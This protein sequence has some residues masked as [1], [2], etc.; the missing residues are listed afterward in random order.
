MVH[1]FSN[2]DPLNRLQWIINLDFQTL[3][4]G[5]LGIFLLFILQLLSSGQIWLLLIWQ[6]LSQ[7][8][9]T[10]GHP[11]FVGLVFFLRLKQQHFAFELGVRVGEQQVFGF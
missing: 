7:R 6:T 1:N 3:E 5:N 2:V 4:L 11:I 10:I 9:V 8:V